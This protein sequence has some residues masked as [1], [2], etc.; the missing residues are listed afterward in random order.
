MDKERMPLGY[1]F[2]SL[3]RED[4]KMFASRYDW[5]PTDLEAARKAHDG[6]MTFMWAQG[7]QQCQ[8]SSL[9]DNKHNVIRHGVRQ[10]ESRTSSYDSIPAPDGLRERIAAARE[11]LTVL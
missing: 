7:K 1:Y 2:H 11:K 9:F 10:G 8:V 4:G 6:S 3:W 5:Q